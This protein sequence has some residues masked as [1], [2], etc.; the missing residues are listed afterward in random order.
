MNSFTWLPRRIWSHSDLNYVLVILN[1]DISNQ[2][3]L[4]KL[5]N[6]AS[7]RVLVDGGANNWLA[8]SQ[9]RK[10]DIIDPIPNLVTGDFDSPT[11]FGWVWKFGWVWNFG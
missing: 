10:R 8:L 3:R 11:L 5:W 1:S 7:F 4:I 9:N 2:D 6:R